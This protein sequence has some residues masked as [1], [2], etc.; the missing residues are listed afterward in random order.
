MKNKAKKNRWL[1]SSS[2]VINFGKSLKNSFTTK[3]FS[4]FLTYKMYSNGMESR[5][6]DWESDNNKNKLVNNLQFLVDVQEYKDLCQK[7]PDDERAIIFKMNHIIDCYI[8]NRILPKIRIDITKELAD[9]ILYQKD[10]LSPYLFLEA[11]VINKLNH[12]L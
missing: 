3:L 11:N 5:F 4:K 12:F 7:N 1:Y 9:E 6:T 8:N 10:Y 2:T